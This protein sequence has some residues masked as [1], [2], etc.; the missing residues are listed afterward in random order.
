ML[1]LES[2]TVGMSVE[3]GGG[4]V[5]VALGKAAAVELSAGVSVIGNEGVKV[6]TDRAAATLTSSSDQAAVSSVPACQTN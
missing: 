6:N 4:G 1:P 5:K 3:V 2:T